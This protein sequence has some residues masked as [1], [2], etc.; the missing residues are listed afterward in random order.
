MAHY[1][2]IPDT[3]V[4][5]LATK[6]KVK[7]RGRDLEDI[8]A[9]I[10]K[11]EKEKIQYLES[12]FQF[13]GG[14]SMGFT[15]CEPEY[16]FPDKS[17]TPKLFLESLIKET[18]IKASNVN[19]EWRPTLREEIQI[20]AVKHD[21]ND[22]YLKLV[23]G[24]PRSHVDGYATR[25]SLKAQFVN[26]VIHFS[27]QIIELRCNASERDIFAEYVLKLLGYGMPAKWHSW[28]TINNEQAKKIS[29]HLKADLISTELD[30]KTT[31]GSMR[32]N[33][34]RSTRVNLRSD[35]A[36][37]AILN[38]IKELNLPIDDANDEICE[39]EYT[40]VTTGIKIPVVF[41][42]N[43]KQQSFKFKK[44]VTEGVI[45]EV[46]D[47]IIKVSFAEQ[48]TQRQMAATSE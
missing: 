17:K 41:E 34:T 14:S 4:R 22:V 29:A 1:D 48:L 18:Y 20:C 39:Y 44:P 45:A 12:Q 30:I 36:M 43:I 6:L 38:K 28:T 23:R 47:A 7:T 3:F 13:T 21:G 8:I 15:I 26:I 24:I 42:M 40:D 11:E 5:K 27:D 16:R 9:D 32:F 19:R 10:E 33:A 37:Q 31:V 25:T 46:L 35:K 2:N